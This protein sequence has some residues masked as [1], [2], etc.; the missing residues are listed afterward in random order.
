MNLTEPQKLWIAALR[1]GEYKQGASRLSMSGKFCCLGV[2]CETAIRNGIKIDRY[3]VEDSTFDDNVIAYD[4]AVS[5]APATAFGWVGLIA[6]DGSLKDID[7]ASGHPLYKFCSLSM[8]NDEGASFEEIADLLEKHP[9]AVF[10]QPH[11]IP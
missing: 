9:E 5:V 3:E 7:A 1:S 2:L 10:V 11:A 4:G 8:A 6:P